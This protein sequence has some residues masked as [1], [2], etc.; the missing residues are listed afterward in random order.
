MKKKGEQKL[1][2]ATLEKIADFNLAQRMIGEVAKN[3]SSNITDFSK[4]ILALAIIEKSSSTATSF[5]QIKTDTLPYGI[6]SDL[7]EELPDF[8]IAYTS[9]LRFRS[10]CKWGMVSS[11]VFAIW[12]I[13]LSYMDYLPIELG[14]PLTIL[15]VLLSFVFSTKLL[16][17]RK[18]LYGT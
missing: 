8:L 11:L 7:K 17:L 18:T 14:G 6:I 9:L 4:V 5:R 13:Y 16:G 2:E 3:I 1:E 10:F 15:F 12:G